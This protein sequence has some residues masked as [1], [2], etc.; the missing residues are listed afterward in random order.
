MPKYLTLA[1]YGTGAHLTH[2]R[3]VVLFF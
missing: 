3:V 2:L 1:T